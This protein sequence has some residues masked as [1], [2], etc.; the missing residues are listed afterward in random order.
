MRKQRNEDLV[1]AAWQI[2][3]Q[4]RRAYRLHQENRPVMEFD[5]VERRIY[6]YPYAG[7]RDGLSER[8]KKLLDREYKD[9]RANRQI[10]V[11]VKDSET[12]RLISFS[13]DE[14]FE[15]GQQRDGP[16]GRSSRCASSSERRR[17]SRRYPQQV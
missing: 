8:S 6:A 4:I 5:V 15:G 2:Q 12:R 11:F 1:Q 10:V 3:D 13:I 7:Y 14:D 17:G 16:R 9:A